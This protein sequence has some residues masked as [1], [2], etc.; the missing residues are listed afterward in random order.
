MMNDVTTTATTDVDQTK[1]VFDME[2]TIAKLK[3]LPDKNGPKDLEKTIA[4]L[5]PVLRAAKKRGYT[6]P[7]LAEL[8]TGRGLP[9]SPATLR[10]YIPPVKTKKK[11]T[12]KSPPAAVPATQVSAENARPIP[13][14]P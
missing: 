9:I 6:Y 10:Q 1:P 7:E 11:T 2:S 8:L 4:R 5:A 13:T 14:T 3:A 12:E